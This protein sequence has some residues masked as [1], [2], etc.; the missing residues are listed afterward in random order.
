MV[1]EKGASLGA[2]WTA[3]TTETETVVGEMRFVVERVKIQGDEKGVSV[4]TPEWG[5]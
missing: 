4:V 2:S 3:C 1:N 5:G